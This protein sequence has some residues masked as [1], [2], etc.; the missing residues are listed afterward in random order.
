MHSSFDLSGPHFQSRSHCD[1]SVRDI[2]IIVEIR[3][4]N[5]IIAYHSDFRR[6]GWAN[7]R[8][9][10]I[11]ICTEDASTKYLLSLKVKNN[12]EKSK[13]KNIWPSENMKEYLRSNQL[14][15]EEK[16]LLFSHISKVFSK[17]L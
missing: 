4:T 13:S 14:S 17:I 5:S 10:T 11:T 3:L 2:F 1:K 12:Q 7:Y 9:T 6:C 8:K 15:T 16:K